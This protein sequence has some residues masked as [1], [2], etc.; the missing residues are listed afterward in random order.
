MRFF[1]HLHQTLT[2]FLLVAGCTSTQSDCG[3]LP[4]QTEQGNAGC[5]VVEDGKLLMI[6]Q[7][8]SGN[9]SLPGGTAEPGERAVCTALR[10]TR[11]ET[12]YQVIV[13]RQVHQFYNG[14]RLYLC[15]IES[16]LENSLNGSQ[17]TQEVDTKIDT[18]EVQNIAWL[19]RQGRD[20]VPWRFEDQRDL[21][22]RLVESLNETSFEPGH[23]QAPEQQTE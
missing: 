21:I 14:F 18:M 16:S 15:S 8:F 4:T 19:D 7:R 13:E 10:E 17:A 5:L 12:G 22:Q 3:Q 2:A 9:W 6:Q 1:G 23:D 20:Q 11:E